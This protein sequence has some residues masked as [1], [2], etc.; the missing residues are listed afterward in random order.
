MAYI[1]QELKTLLFLYL[2]LESLGKLGIRNTGTLGPGTPEHG[3]HGTRDPGTR[4]PWDP[5]TRGL[6]PRNPGIGTRNPK[7][8]IWSS[9]I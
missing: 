6:E 9:L 2:D 4:E 3:N 5:G 7:L 8:D 1:F